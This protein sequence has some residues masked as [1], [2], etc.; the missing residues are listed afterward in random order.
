MGMTDRQFDAYQARTIKILNEIIKN[1]HDYEA[2]KAGIKEFI[3]EME[4]DLKR[5]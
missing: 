2:L 5:P 3:T 1:N 4:N